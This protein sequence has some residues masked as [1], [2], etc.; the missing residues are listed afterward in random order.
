MPSA[1]DTQRAAAWAREVVVLAGRGGQS[2]RCSAWQH[3]AAHEFLRQPRIPARRPG[4]AR[5]CAARLLHQ[6]QR[7]RPLPG[8]AGRIA[9]GRCQRAIPTRRYTALRERLARF[10]GVDPARI[11]VA[12]SASEFIGRIT[13]AV[14]QQGGSGG[15]AAAAQLRRLPARRRR[16]G[17]RARA[18]SRRRSGLV[19]RSVEPAG[20]G[21]RRTCRAWST[22]CRRS[23]LRARPRLRAAATRRQPG[24]R[25]DA[26]A[27][28][29]GSCGRPTRR[30]A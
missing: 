12:A 28:A 30:W 8:G 18:G 27:T 20:P 14:A 25:R 29:S 11:V 26:A 17:P 19:L 2:S 13:A 4:C 15:L 3:G 1:A 9:A 21:R 16:V 22:A 10:H 6:R 7:L 5:R 23:Q 24:P